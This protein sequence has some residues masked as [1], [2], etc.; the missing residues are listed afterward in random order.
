MPK[1]AITGKGG[2]GKTTLSALLAYTYAQEGN[3]VLVIDADPDANLASAL[4]VPPYGAYNKPVTVPAGTTMEFSVARRFDA[5]INSS[6]AVNGFAQVDFIDTLRRD[7]RCR[8]Q[9]PITIA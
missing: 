9:I 4:G 8:T 6:V 1:L 7:R 5:M 2:V 3:K